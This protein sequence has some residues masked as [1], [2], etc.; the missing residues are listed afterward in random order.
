MQN[1]KEYKGGIHTAG[2]ATDKVKYCCTDFTYRFGLRILLT[3]QGAL[4][5]IVALQANTLISTAIDDPPEGQS[6]EFNVT[7]FGI[8]MIFIFAVIILS[9]IKEYYVKKH[10]DYQKLDYDLESASAETA[11]HWAHANHQK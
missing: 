8:I 11:T 5:F 7:R 2:Q 6:K 10:N 3:F 1:Y 4:L 9:Y